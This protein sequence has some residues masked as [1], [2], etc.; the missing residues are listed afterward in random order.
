ML[1]TQ[2]KVLRRFWYALMPISQ[3]KDGPLPFTLLGEKLVVWLREDGTPAALQDRCCHRT[4]RLSKGF[5]EGMGG[6][7]APEDTPGGGLTMVVTLPLFSDATR[8]TD[9]GRASA[10]PLVHEREEERG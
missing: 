6:T 8:Q 7:L 10:A 9:A 5:V 3:L 4:A 2:Q 1:V